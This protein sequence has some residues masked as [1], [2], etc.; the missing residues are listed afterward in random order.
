MYSVEYLESS[1]LKALTNFSSTKVNNT[2]LIKLVCLSTVFKLSIVMLALISGAHRD[3]PNN[4]KK[5]KLI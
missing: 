3:P 1:F 5:F 4:F 2:S